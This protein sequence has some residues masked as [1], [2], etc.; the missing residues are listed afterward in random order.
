MRGSRRPLATNWLWWIVQNVPHTYSPKCEHT[1]SQLKT[2]VVC[3]IQVDSSLL[4]LLL[5]GLAGSWSKS[6][7]TWIESRRDSN[8]KPSSDIVR[9]GSLHGGW[10]GDYSYQLLLASFSSRPRA[11]NHLY[12]MKCP[13][14]VFD[15]IWQKSYR[16]F[17]LVGHMSVHIGDCN[18]WNENET[19]SLFSNL[20]ALLR[21]WRLWMLSNLIVILNR[22]WCLVDTF[23]ESE[24]GCQHVY[25]VSNA[26]TN[27]MWLNDNPRSNYVQTS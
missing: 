27:S 2:N 23:V 22:I 6:Q 25:G 16:Y 26:V 14:S 21:L 4:V 10:R 1:C 12:E 19:T 5:S 8:P 3:S 15:I 17:F 24:N 7:R 20:V 9:L 11:M 18:A 13:S